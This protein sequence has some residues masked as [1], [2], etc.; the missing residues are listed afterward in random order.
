MAIT[1]EKKSEILA[2]LSDVLTNAKSLVFVGFKGI[3]G[4]DTTEMRRALKDEDVKYFVAKKRLIKKAIADNKVAGDLPELEGEL[5][6]AYTTSEDT[7]APARLIHEYGKKHEGLTILGGVFEE[8]LADA[9]KM[10][11]I[12]TI[13]SL[14][15]LRGMF[16]NV[17]NSPI[18]RTAVALGQIAEKKGE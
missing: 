11:E 17:I 15:V 6:I 9:S 8:S 14:Q 13:P 16:V 1:R 18:Q 3:G 10:K 7:T 4:N 12:A 2:N 5:A